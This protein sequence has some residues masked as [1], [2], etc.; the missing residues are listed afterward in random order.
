MQV[1]LRGGKQAGANMGTSDQPSN[2][3]LVSR[4]PGRQRSVYGGTPARHGPLGL[5]ETT[6]SVLL[7]DSRWAARDS[8]EA[9]RGN[10]PVEGGG[11]MEAAP[12]AEFNAPNQI[13]SS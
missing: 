3:R 7:F 4:P 10:V 12:M 2:S 8:A 9:K 13:L 5:M 1:T 11:D 6:P